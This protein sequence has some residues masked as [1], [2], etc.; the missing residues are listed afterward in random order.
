MDGE[1][2]LPGA[3]PPARD[4]CLASSTDMAL[5]IFGDTSLT[6]FSNTASRASCADTA[7]AV[8]SKDSVSERE[9]WSSNYKTRY[10]TAVL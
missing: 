4:A 9:C 6:Y 3:A 1:P 10:S 5:M 2:V 7:N 8:R